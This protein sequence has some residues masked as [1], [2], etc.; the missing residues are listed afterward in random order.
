MESQLKKNDCRRSDELCVVCT[1]PREFYA[2]L[3]KRSLVL[4]ALV[5]QT[6]F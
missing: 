3:C 2:A 6:C 4:A 5:A 1:H